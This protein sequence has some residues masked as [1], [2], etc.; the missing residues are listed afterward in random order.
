MKISIYKNK[1]TWC[2]KH[3]FT[4]SDLLNTPLLNK[5][6]AFDAK[7]R[8]RFDLEGLLPTHVSTLEEQVER[9]YREIKRKQDPLQQHIG[10]ISLQNRNEVLFYRLLHDHLAEFM[11]VIYTPT[12]GKACQEFSQI[13]R[14]MRA[15]W[16]TPE[17]KGNIKKVLQNFPF[18]D[19]RLVVVTDNERILGLGDQGA[20]GIG[21]PVGKL[22]LYCVTAG[23]HPA[24]TL[25]VSLDVGTDNETLLKDPLYLGYKHKRLRGKAYDDIV[26]EFALA[27]K[28]TF[29]KAVLQWEDFKKQTA[30]S[31]LEKYQ[32]VLPSFN[33]DIQGTAGVALAAILSGCK[34]NN[35]SIADQRLMIL[36]AGAAGAGIAKLFMVAQKK[37]GCDAGLKNVA[38]FDREGLLSNQK[39]IDEAYKK[40][41]AW[42]K[43][44]LNAHGIENPEKLTAEDFISIFKPT[45]LIG[46]SGQPG[47]FTQT[48][49]EALSRVCESPMIFPFSNPTDSSE[50]K[51]I[52]L[53]QWTKGNALI[54]TGSPFE[55]VQL[56]D[57]TFPITQGNNVYIFPGVGLGAILAQCKKITESMFYA[58]ALAVHEKLTEAELAQGH[59]LP[60]V[61]RLREVAQHVALKVAQTAVDEKNTRLY[62]FSKLKKIL[63]EFTWFPDYPIYK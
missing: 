59:L 30:F 9:M 49:I 60:P 4:G 55:P 40:E 53:L 19:I 42:N 3:G 14:R 41:F 35:A 24:H 46:T 13:H 5:G 58:A 10:L 39:N 37:A 56:F 57:Q 21:I 23:I 31:V 12:V 62:G 47:A 50:A 28:K 7:E 61:E 16:I 45:I 6:S 18:Q 26:S 43:T 54:A 48:M 29:P 34:K 20:G 8:K 63:E 36:G 17:H 2:I 38:L 52:D 22:A 11:P 27:I 51:P 25:A 44:T 33:D 32:N 15:L 1:N